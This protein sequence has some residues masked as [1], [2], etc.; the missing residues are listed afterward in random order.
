M[1]I[2]LTALYKNGTTVDYFGGE[3]EPETVALDMSVISDV[4]SESYQNDYDAV[5]SLKNGT[6]KTFIRVND[7]SSITVDGVTESE[8]D[9]Y[10]PGSILYDDPIKPEVSN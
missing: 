1:K 2:K 8:C 3:S 5:I 9:G 6:R 4:V 7:T 10:N